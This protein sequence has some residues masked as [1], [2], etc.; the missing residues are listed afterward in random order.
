MAVI[1][2]D[3]DS[4]QYRYVSDSGFTGNVNACEIDC[5]KS[6]TFVARICFIRAD[7]SMPANAVRDGTP[8]LYYPLTQFGDIIGIFR[9]EKALGVY[10]DTETNVGAITGAVEQPGKK[11][12]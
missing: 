1:S 3:F 11:L 9:Y 6:N 8:Y 5:Y 7:R 2:T 12:K 10:L 4:Y